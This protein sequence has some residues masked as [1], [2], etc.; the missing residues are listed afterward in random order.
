MTAQYK[1]ISFDFFEIKHKIPSKATETQI[2]EI[3]SKPIDIALTLD[4]ICDST[5]IN[6]R[7][8]STGADFE[9]RLMDL[10]YDKQLKCYIGKLSKL[11]L[12]NLPY[13]GRRSSDE[14]EATVNSED[15]GIDEYASFLINTTL[16]C[17]IFER[18]QHGAKCN[19]LANLLNVNFDAK[20]DFYPIEKIDSFERFERAVTSMTKIEI[21]LSGLNNVANLY[22]DQPADALDHF[23]NFAGGFN[24]YFVTLTIS[25][26]YG[27]YL[28]NEQKGFIKKVWDRFSSSLE[29]APK[30]T[31]L[32]V[33]G[34]CG[35]S[36]ADK[37]HT[38]I[39]DLLEDRLAATKE[40]GDTE[41]MYNFK[42][43]VTLLKELWEEYKEI[44][45]PLVTKK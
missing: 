22:K 29:D 45:E 18:T 37:L 27:K 3:C 16:N 14:A 32:K 17:M 36:N 21:A 26:P 35:S 11:R 8:W 31:K 40:L 6:E 43:R 34:K 28:A 30:M 12:T 7:T 9:I 10:T 41:K 1:E 24:P 44:L 25:N 38:E 2:K 15:E 42:S 4:S 39:I 33:S 23:L 13:K 5:D 20:I 19:A